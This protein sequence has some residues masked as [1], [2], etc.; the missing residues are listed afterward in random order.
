MIYFNFILQLKL[1]IFFPFYFDPYSFNFGIDFKSLNI[2]EK[3]GFFF[4]NFILWLKLILYFVFISVLI[5]WIFLFFYFLYI[6]IS[7]LVH[8]Y[9]YIVLVFV[10]NIYYYLFCQG[11][12]FF[13]VVLKFEF[14]FV[15]IW[16]LIFIIFSLCSFFIYLFFKS[17]DILS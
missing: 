9:M 15:I 12:I 6:Y 8:V 16:K 10:F 3:F 7:Q 11:C 14:E 5:L 2:F 17:N 1:I 4:F 13:I